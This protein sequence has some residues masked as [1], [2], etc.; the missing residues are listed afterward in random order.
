MAAASCVQEEKEEKEIQEPSD[1]IAQGN[2]IV[3]RNASGRYFAIHKRTTERD[4]TIP[5]FIGILEGSLE[6]L[7]NVLL[8]YVLNNMSC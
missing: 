6:A 8:S 2:N 4:V 1:A 5:F 3:C 7:I